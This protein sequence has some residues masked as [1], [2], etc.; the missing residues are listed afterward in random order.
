MEKRKINKRAELTTAQLV[1]LLVLIASF[2]IL[3]ILFFRLNLGEESNKEICHNSVLLKDKTGGF[4]GSLDC[5]TNYVC[6]SGGD[7]CEDSFSSKV[8]VDPS[9]KDEI[10]KAI[11]DEEVGCWWQF[12]EGK[13]NNYAGGVGDIA[14]T[15]VYCAVCSVIQ[16]DKKVQEEVSKITYPEY[17][18]YL[19]RTEKGDSQTYLQYLFKTSD[20]SSLR[21]NEHFGVVD[22][23]SDFFATKEKYSIITGIDSNANNNNVDEG[24]LDNDLLGVYVIPTIETSDTGCT[25]FITKA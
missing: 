7:D 21:I 1:G 17:Y 4:V 9:N 23:N 12:G 18:S 24:V 5:R 20:P 13:V 25:E 16:F 22:I 3:L 6:I 14:P 15:K 8:N 10:M 11:A 19:S 2:V